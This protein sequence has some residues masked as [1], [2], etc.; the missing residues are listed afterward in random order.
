MRGMLRY[1]T[2]LLVLAGAVACSDETGTSGTGTVVVRLTDAPADNLESAVIY[3]SEVT[4]KGSDASTNEEIISNTK[5]SF[6]LLTL[7]N[8]VT[9]T[10]GSATVPTGTYSQV[11]LLVDSARVVLKAGHT[12]ADGS[13]TAKLT[14]PSGS[15][16][17]LKVNFSPPI[18]VTEGQTVLLVD[19]DVSQSFV[20]QGPPDHPNSISFKPVLH[21]TAL[22]V[23]A[24]ISGTVTPATANATVYAIAGTDTAATAF[25]NAT[26]GAYT[27]SPLAP[28]TYV[29]AAKA[30]GF[31]VALSASIT[32]GNSEAKT[33]VN[34]VLVAGP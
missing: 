10:L 3:I 8:G 12:F 19:F 18:T 13:T 6:D 24:S 7:Q 20:F 15:Q 31:A 9:A 27:L 21:A 26:T 1:V 32:L 2:P 30:T 33:G 14:V 5:A 4:L 17:G 11:R 28:G 29:V 22:D 16:S 34:L 25:P 23:A